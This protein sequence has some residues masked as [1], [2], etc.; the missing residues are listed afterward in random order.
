[1][2]ITEENVT[3][4]TTT[5]QNE[6][7]SQHERKS[8]LA[9]AIDTYR[10]RRAARATVKSVERELS[11]YTT[12]AELQDLDAMIERCADDNDQVFGPIIERIRLRA[13]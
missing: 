11:T 1:M 13:A 9:T 4:T 8:A 5:L 12:P 10:D 7:T 3:T 6:S 2:T